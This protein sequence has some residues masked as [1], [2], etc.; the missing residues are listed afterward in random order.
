MKAI[1]YLAGLTLAMT[2]SFN[3]ARASDHVGVYALIDK[4]ILEP[5]PDG[6]ERIQIWG[7]FALAKK[8]N[9]NDYEEPARG[10]LYFTLQKGKEEICKKEWADL[11]KIAGTKQVV[12]FGS[13]WELKARVRQ[14]EEKTE[15]PDD[16]PVSF[17][18]VKVRTDTNYGPIRTLLAHASH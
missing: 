8:N 14:A 1:Q 3:V 13:R 18:L 10:Y 5:N 6:P 15:K 17:G 2:L 4:V 7:T 12:A 9:P 16:Y 11:K